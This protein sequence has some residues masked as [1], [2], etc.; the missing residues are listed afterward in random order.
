MTGW[1]RKIEISEKAVGGRVGLLKNVRWLFE[2]YREISVSIC[3]IGVDKG[4]KRGG[5]DRQTDRKKI[6]SSGLPYHGENIFFSIMGIA[7]HREVECSI[8]KQL[9]VLDRKS[10]R[11]NSSRLGDQ[12]YEQVET[13]KNVCRDMIKRRSV[14]RSLQIGCKK[15]D[16]KRIEMR[17]IVAIKK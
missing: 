1:N 3:T 11:L 4:Q 8:L 15:T 13:V 7:L 6:I 9:I 5:S 17:L 16:E 10:T 12:L 14:V 2:K